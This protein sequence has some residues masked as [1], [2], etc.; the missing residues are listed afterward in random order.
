M[1][2]CLF[3]F[4][5]WVTNEEGK[6]LQIRNRE[7]FLVIDNFSKGIIRQ[8]VRCIQHC[9]IFVRHSLYLRR[10]SVT[11]EVFLLDFTSITSILL[12]W[13]WPKSSFGFLHKMLQKKPKE[14]LGQPNISIILLGVVLKTDFFLVFK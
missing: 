13:G 10:H 11:Y 14:L 1:F 2:V 3:V 4:P 5:S 12:Y 9:D 7:Y 6:I 8:I